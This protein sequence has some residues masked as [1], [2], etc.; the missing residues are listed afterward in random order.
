MFS[1]NELQLLCNLPYTFFSVSVCSGCTI[2]FTSPWGY[3]N[4]DPSK[5]VL[6]PSDRLCPGCPH[7]ENAVVVMPSDA[8]INTKAFPLLGLSTSSKAFGKPQG[9][10]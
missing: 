2:I 10:G 4:P 5:L 8:S 1:F 7:L 3:F 6:G 9:A